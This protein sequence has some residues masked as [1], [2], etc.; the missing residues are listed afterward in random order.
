MWTGR[1]GRNSALLPSQ[2]RSALPRVITRASQPE[3]DPPP[4]SPHTLRVTASHRAVRLSLRPSARLGRFHGDAAVPGKGLIVRQRSLIAITAALAAG[5]L[6]PHRLRLARRRRRLGLRQRRQRWWH[7]R[8]HRRRRP[9]D[10]RPVRAGPR[11]QELG[12]SRG[13]DGQQGEL[14]RGRQV[15]DRSPRRPGP[16]LRR[17]AERH[18][19]RRQRRRPRRRRPAELL[20]RRVHAEGLRHG[21]TG[22]GLPGQHQPRAHP[23]RRLADQEGPPLQVVLPHRDHGRHPGP[24]RRPVRLQRLQEA[25]GLRHRRQEDLRRRSRQDLH[26]GV[27]EARRPGR[28]HR[29]HQPG[30]QGL[31]RGRHQGQ[32]LRRRRRLLRRRIPAGRPAQQA[33]QGGRR[34]D[35]AGRR[36]RHLQ[37]RLHQARRRQR[38]R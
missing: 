32:E 37:R 15:R 36:R 35:S 5:A 19:A 22:R 27:Q 33:D 8:R 6:H 30:H 21:Q 13:Q 4:R 24:V 29:A 16:A 26:R 10:R 28:R 12:G 2:Y 14:R 20:G 7:H 17:P 25:Q 23:G 34:E 11:H 3:S 18:P 31:Q 1:I 9:A 38:H